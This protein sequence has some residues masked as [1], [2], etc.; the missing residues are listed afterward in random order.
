MAVYMKIPAGAGSQI[1][2]FCCGQLQ[3]II[4]VCPWQLYKN[5]RWCGFSD[6]HLYVVGSFSQSSWSAHGHYYLCRL[7]IK[8]F[9]ARNAILISL[10]GSVVL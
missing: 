5:P 2:I 1:F 8:P 6:F 7:H 9:W 3:L 10:E 4:M